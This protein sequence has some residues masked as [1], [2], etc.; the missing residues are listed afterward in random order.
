MVVALVSMAVTSAAQGQSVPRAEAMEQQFKSALAAYDAGHFA[1][2]A[3]TLEKLQVVA[4]KSFDIHELLGMTY[5]A[6]TKNAK[7]VEQLQQAVQLQPDSVAARTNLA[8]GLVR[9]GK[10]PQAKQ[11]CRQ[12]LALNAADYNA[13]HTLAELYL[14]DDEIEKALPLLKEAQRS[15]PDAADNGYDLALALLL[16]KH[17]EE[18]GELIHSLQAQ[19]DSGELHNLLGRIA[20][21]QGRYVDAANECAAAAHM[22]PSEENLFGWAS[23]LLQHRAYEGAIAVFKSATDRF[24]SSPRLWIGLG[25][26]YY[27]RGEYAPSIS[28][29]LTAADLKP[30]DP[31][32][33]V[34][35]SKAF[36]SSPSQ[37]EQVIER[38]RKYAALQPKNALAQYYY[39]IGLWKGRRQETSEV[40]YKAIESLLQRSIAL[41][42]RNADVHLQLGIVY[43]DDEQYARSFPEYQRALQLN[44]DFADA[45]F[46]LGRYYLRVG[47]KEKAQVQ[48]EAF[49][50]LQAEHQAEIDKERAEVQQ[51]VTTTPPVAPSQP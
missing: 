14:R 5:G 37:A 28:A 36:L 48:I 34:F 12:A 1:E 10:L 33:Y 44:P 29:L 49:K 51:F 9:V 18:A 3:A 17:Y 41:D 30:E 35:L 6:Q 39:A 23:E 7:A 46:R 27:S 24:P 20:E 21:A 25:M 26:A 8:T 4:P 50:K 11:E 15:R 2:A 22:D 43:N 13:N 38:F 42:D 16:V 31:R 47:E 45:H 19:R 32:S 40:D